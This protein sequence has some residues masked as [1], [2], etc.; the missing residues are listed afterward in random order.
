MGYVPG[1]GDRR[2]EQRTGDGVGE[3]GESGRW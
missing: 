3:I 2:P 1:D